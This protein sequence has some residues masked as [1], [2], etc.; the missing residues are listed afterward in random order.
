MTELQDGLLTPSHEEGQFF[1]DLKIGTG[2]IFFFLNENSDGVT[3][4]Y[5]TGDP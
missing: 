2:T 4:I 1:C 5:G 3:S